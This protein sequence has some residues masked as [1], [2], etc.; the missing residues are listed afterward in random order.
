MTDT[1]PLAEG[2][3]LFTSESVTEGH[4][5]KVSDQISDAVLDA[6]LAHGEGEDARVA[7][8]TLVSTNLV[9][10]SGEIRTE[11][12]LDLT[13]IAARRSARSATTA[14]T[15]TSAPTHRG[16][17]V[18]STS[19]PRTSPRASTRL[20]RRARPAPR[21]TTTGAG[22]GDQGM[23]FGYATAETEALMPMPISLAHRLADRLA[24]VRKDGTLRLPRPRRQ[25]SGHGPLPPT[26][27]RSRS[28]G[29]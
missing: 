27:G 19:S 14:S 6:V 8:E 16:A 5:D 25:D 20:T 12:E 23:M 7:C 3:H 29:S 15:P 22:A 28:S 13:E 10:I 24:V 4:P 1:K 2:E 9:V 17:G 26:T 21:T 18:A 11:A